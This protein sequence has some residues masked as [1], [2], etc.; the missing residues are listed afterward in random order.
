MKSVH[1]RLGIEVR[2]L[3]WARA[4]AAAKD[5]SLHAKSAA[6]CIEPTLPGTTIMRS[7]VKCNSRTKNARLPM[8][9]AARLTRQHVGAAA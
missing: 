2:P 8:A 5:E 4:K 3:V 9:I 1:H 7:A 6:A